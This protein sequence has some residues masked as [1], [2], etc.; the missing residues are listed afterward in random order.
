MDEKPYSQK[1][2]H[3]KI[4]KRQKKNHTSSLFDRKE[5]PEEDEG[6]IYPKKSFGLRNS[7]IK[8]P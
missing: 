8:I 2:R 1:P 7:K 6:L 3:I 5:D 4:T